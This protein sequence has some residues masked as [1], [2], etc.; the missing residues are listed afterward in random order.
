[1][2]HG[3]AKAA[4][5]LDGSRPHVNLGESI[6][7]RQKIKQNIHTDTHWSP[8]GFHQ[9]R[10]ELQ[11]LFWAGTKKC[12][13]PYGQQNPPPPQKKIKR[14]QNNIMILRNKRL[15][16]FLKTV[17]SLFGFFLSFHVLMTRLQ[18]A[19]RAP[20]WRIFDHISAHSFRHLP[21]WVLGGWQLPFWC[22]TIPFG[23]YTALWR[24]L[25]NY[26][27]NIFFMHFH[28]AQER[29]SRWE[30]R[31]KGPAL[32]LRCDGPL[33]EMWL[34]KTSAQSRESV[35]LLFCASSNRMIYSISTGRRAN[36]GSELFDSNRWTAQTN[37]VWPH[38]HSVLLLLRNLI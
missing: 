23:K 4:L 22:K 31:F 18:T 36:V 8:G 21:L 10:G 33:M 19:R 14:Y 9:V 2:I 13:A 28:H 12:P 5:P 38:L 20:K 25:L 6:Q 15:K 32:T 17:K 35:F 29:Q 37:M 1:M 26:P 3:S 11:V 24:T 30:A 16:N 34:Q 7:K 27:K